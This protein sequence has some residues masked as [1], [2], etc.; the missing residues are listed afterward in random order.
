MAT[1]QVRE[2]VVREQRGRLLQQARQLQEDAE[3]FGRKG[4]VGG[5]GTRGLVWSVD[6]VTK[7]SLKGADGLS[8]WF[9]ALTGVAWKG[10]R[11]LAA[12]ALGGAHR[13]PQQPGTT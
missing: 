12:Y 6:A 11:G 7:M 2:W 13:A 10:A 8:G 4:G 9:N 5:S 1:G 3:R